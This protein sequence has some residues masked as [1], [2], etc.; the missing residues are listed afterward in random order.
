MKY[1]SVF[2]TIALLACIQLSAQYTGKYKDEVNFADP[3]QIDSSQYFLIP[4]VVDEDDKAAYGNGK[5]IFPWSHYSEM[6]LYNAETRT[7]KK[8]FDGQRAL[9]VPFRSLW[10][11]ERTTE[12]P[13]NFLDKHIVYLVRTENYNKDN[14]LDFDD[15]VYLYISTKS[16]DGLR[17]ITPKGMNVVC[18]TPSRDRKFILV[19]LQVDKNG[20]K[21]F[22]NGD[23]ELYYRIDLLNDVAQIKCYPLEL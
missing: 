10:P 4:K 13:Q 8:M 18:W 11:K 15:P 6:Y 16:G 7:S 17:Q 12:P 2:S 20:N 1:T 19:R 23:D 5:V 3:L 21:K 22:G 14:G 9:I